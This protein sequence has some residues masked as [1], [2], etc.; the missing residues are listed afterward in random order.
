[1]PRFS[2]LLPT[3]NRLELLTLAV[4]TVRRQNFADWEVVIS[5]NSSDEDIAGLVLS[6]GDPRIRYIRTASFVPVTDNWNNALR[7]ST[8]DWVLMLGDDDGL[9][10]GALRHLATV[11]DQFAPDLVYGNAFVFTYPGV[12]PDAPAGSLRPYSHSALFEGRPDPYFLDRATA[13]DLV[14][15]AMH[16]EMAYT[17]NMQH[18]VIS[19][20]LV[21]R[22]AAGGDFF[23]SP[24]PDFYATNLLF[25]EA[26]RIVVD[27]ARSVTIGVSR[28]SF[29]YFFFNRRESE[30]VAFLNNAVDAG[31]RAALRDVVLPG[32]EDRTSWLIAMLE[33]ERRS[34]GAGALAPD[35]R[36][37]R[38]LQI[39]TVY[40]ADPRAAD[41][42]AERGR[43]WPLLGLRERVEALFFAVGARLLA[44]VPAT[45]RAGLREAIRRRIA[46][47][48]GF[49]S[50]VGPELGDMLE[51]YSHLERA[52]GPSSP[53]SAVIR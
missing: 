9:T 42:S 33:I 15:R 39:A 24:Y 10:P 5:D 47:S 41:T 35:I 29:G 43:M 38:R 8:G 31:D 13:R 1:M 44:L 19:R 23:R 40:G 36:R 4:E 26:A 25:L 45:A 12:L 53:A 50:P 6:V 37:Y 2:I 32:R 46:R 16:F 52:A 3:R 27:P 18:S 28:R 14:R 49:S 22:L 30:G 51:V 48:P 11:I 7:H 34:G 17:F 20:Q 21:D